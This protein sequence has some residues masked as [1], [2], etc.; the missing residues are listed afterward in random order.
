MLGNT[1]LNVT[2][3]VGQITSTADVTHN[4]EQCTR[5]VLQAAD[6]GAKVSP[7]SRL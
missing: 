2:Q 1:L 6:G 5:L 7:A 3:A 4:L